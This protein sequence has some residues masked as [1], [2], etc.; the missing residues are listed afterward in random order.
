M[1]KAKIAIT[2]PVDQLRRIRK[3]VRAGRAESV[4]GYISEILAEQESRESTRALLDELLELHG[5]PSPEDYEWA[6][7]MLTPPKP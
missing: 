5:A 2:L 3:E 1:P 7:R 4:S 6:Q